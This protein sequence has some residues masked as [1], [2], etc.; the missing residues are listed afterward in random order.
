MERSRAPKPGQTTT[1]ARPPRSTIR[2]SGARGSSLKIRI[3]SGWSAIVF[4][5]LSFR[6]PCAIVIHLWW[7]QP[8]PVRDPPG[9]M[10]IR[11]LVY[12]GR[13]MARIDLIE[14]K[15]GLSPAQT[16]L[17]D[18]IVNSRGFLVRPFGVLLHAPKQ[19]EHLARLGHVVRY[20]SGLDGDVRE[21]AILSTGQMTGCRYVWDTHVEIALR[22]GV[23]Q[24]VLDH[25]EGIE[26]AQLTAKESALIDL[27][28]ELCTSSSLSAAT[29]ERARTE[30][31]QEAILEISVL[32]GYYTLL[33]YTMA[34]FD[35]CG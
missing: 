5:R 8:A 30:L 9:L 7:R 12:G 6:F 10:G 25:L 2:S 17:F 24:E 15:E 11:K 13:E 34:T 16:R 19:A 33:S 23:R 28:G 3:R 29:F 20:E 14:N 1:Q 4:Y 32:V 22:E 18:W 21:L 26:A 27:I 31:D 35:I